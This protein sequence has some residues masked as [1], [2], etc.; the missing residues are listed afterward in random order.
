MIDDIPSGSDSVDKSLFAD[1]SSVYLGHRKTN[2]LVNKIQQ[3]RFDITHN[4]CNQN[5]FKISINKATEVRFSRKTQSPTINIKI[6]QKYIKNILKNEAKFLGAIF[7][8]KLHWKPHI[9]Y[10]RQMQ[11]RLNLMRA[12]SEY[13][14]G[15]SKNCF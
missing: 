13:Q 7:D 11:K 10:I 6:D 14:L 2:L 9:K 15:A 12:V 3:L 4:W 8:R 5:G 1:D